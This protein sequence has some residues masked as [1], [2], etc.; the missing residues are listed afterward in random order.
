MSYPDCLHEGSP[1]PRERLL[2][3]GPAS[4]TDQE[5]VA[6]LLGHG[7]K[8]HPVSRVAGLLVEE[9][10]ARA[11]A[12]SLCQTPGVGQARAA[13]LLAGIELGRRLAIPG[14]PRIGCPEDVFELLVDMVD[15]D[16]E[17]FVALYLDAR[18]RVIGQETVS[19]GTLTASLVH[20]REVFAPALQR[21]AATVVVAHNHPSGDPT[22]SA[23]D[24]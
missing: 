18:R 14:G 22:P 4:L 15:Y 11:T 24:V 23:E 16:R 20:P 6:V 7:V 9:G 1:R 19:V 3:E 8:D 12:A 13:A 17:H 2:S 5:L 10:L 21:R